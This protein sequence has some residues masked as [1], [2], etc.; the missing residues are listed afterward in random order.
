LTQ[1]NLYYHQC[2]K[3]ATK[4][5]LFMFGATTWCR[6]NNIPVAIETCLVRYRVPRTKCCLSPRPFLE[7]ML[8]TRAGGF[9]F[10]LHLSTPQGYSAWPVSID[11]G[12]IGERVRFLSCSLADIYKFHSEQFL[13]ITVGTCVC[14][15][16]G[17]I[18][19]C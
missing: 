16:L 3:Y 12:W 7:A 9:H 13:N 14:C 15:M 10:T 8:C 4:I 5:F 2:S 18:L 19:K 17:R 1:Q 11:G 6:K